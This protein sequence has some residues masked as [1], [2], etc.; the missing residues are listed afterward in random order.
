VW[1]SAR[2]LRRTVV[3]AAALAVV[4]LTGGPGA[5][6]ADAHAGL[7]RTDPVAGAA[8]GA[9]P[10]SVQ[11]V[12][13]E[14]VEPE[15]SEVRVLDRAGMAQQIGP[16][17]SGD[18]S[19]LRVPLRKLPR[20]V[21]TV[22]WRSLSAV[23][24]HATAGSFAFGV[25]AKPTGG[26]ARARSTSPGGSGVEMLAR[27]ALIAGLVALLGAAV[28]ALGGFAGSTGSALRLAAAGWLLAAIG[29]A[30]LVA[31]QRQSAGASV[32]ELL[33]SDV[34]TA[35]VERAVGLG[36]A[37]L[38][39]VVAWRTCPSTAGGVEQRRP[40][41]AAHATG[42]RWRLA[43]A[44]G[45][46]WR[47]WR[48]VR[49]A[50]RR[51]RVARAAGQGS[52]AVLAAGRRWRDARAAGRRW[53][54]ARAAGRRWR[55]VRAAGRRWRVAHAAGPGSRAALAAG[56]GSRAALVAVVVAAAAVMAAHVAAGHAAAGS[57][58]SAVGVGSQ[59]AHFMAVAIWIGGLAALLL[60]LR[61]QPSGERA[62]AVKRFSV[63]ALGGLV[64]VAAAG[65]LRAIDE[66]GAVDELWSTGYGRA[67]LAKVALLA[68]IASIAARRRR[69]ARDQGGGASRPLAVDLGSLRRTAG[70]E[71]VLATAALALAAVLGTI[72]PPLAGETAA[73]GLTATGADFATTIR[74]R[75]TTASDEPGANSFV[76]RITDYDS[77]EPVRGAQVRLRFEPL[78]DPGVDP[79]SLQLT[80]RPGS[81]T[82]AAAGAGLAFDGRWR[83]TA[84]VQRAR[85]AVE[86]PLEL[87]VHGPEHFI[88]IERR[89]GVAP[90]YSAQVIGVGYVR[91]APDPERAGPSTLNVDVFT[92]FEDFAAIDEL[93]VTHAA[94]KGGRT[95]QLAVR[96]LRA[97]G[98]F[99]AP[100]TLAKGANTI[101]VVARD[102][103]GNRLRAV[104]ELD[105]PD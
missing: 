86:V 55:V 59:W 58:P 54:L 98:R 50:G 82:Y 87:E 74:V 4:A 63:V 16:P 48:V 37:G 96:R 56:P 24:G 57:W 79:T 23:D 19:S 49:A 75:L 65:T 92:V 94:G 90:R 22:M 14:R 36:A 88:S 40:A 25:R 34:G 76:A 5:G 89:P 27:L 2:G 93:V 103:Q 38:A 70:A 6:E 62:A 71:L 47:G 12:F 21:Y 44:A 91:I 77:G 18:P 73:P 9:A 1:T 104:F 20:G 64:V 3:V 97:R 33:D 43:L 99:S 46:G 83:V 72:A 68:L 101:A 15:L 66:L 60:G 7:V 13:S 81:G 28:A 17:V 80:P 26:A 69:R 67:I 51:W 53:R 78:D 45:G 31:A 35:L 42:Q 32:G 10:S 41:G 102:R 29:L 100:V 84:L 39:L 11:L 95:R 85:D 105:V 61:G 8:L 52:R 30:G